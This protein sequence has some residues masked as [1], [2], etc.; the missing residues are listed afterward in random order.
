MAKGATVVI[1]RGPEGAAAMGAD[2][3][4]ISA[5]AL[6]VDVVDTIG[7]GDVFNAAFLAALAAGKPLA[8]CLAEGTGVA[9]R[10]IS[11]SPRSYGEIPA[12]AARRA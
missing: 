1:K 9:S 5:A 2:G 8:A 3:R 12:A 7:A 4:L 10:A 11:T 6:K